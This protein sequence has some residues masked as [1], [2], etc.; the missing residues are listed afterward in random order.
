MLPAFVRFH[1]KTHLN[2]RPPL[3]LA[4]LADQVQTG[5]A[6]GAVALAG[7]ARNARAHDVFPVGGPAP[8][9]RDHVVEVQITP[10]KSPA[11]VLAYIFIAFKNIVP[12]ELYFLSGKPIITEQ[13]NYTRNAQPKGHCR[14]G[15]RMRLGLGEILPFAKAESL[16]PIGVIVINHLRVPGEKQANGAAHGADVHRLP[17]A[18][19]HEHGLVQRQ[20]HN[21]QR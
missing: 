1:A 18:V 4:R 20:T 10:I 8:I 21:D 5:L 9:A 11:A 12:R 2:K 6:G 15:I 17:K 13:Q 7:V 19:E 16:K 3:G 14:N